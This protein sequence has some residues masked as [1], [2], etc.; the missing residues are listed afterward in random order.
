MN[1]EAYDP[2]DLYD[3][4]FAEAGVLRPEMRPV[5]QH[6]YQAARND[7]PQLKHSLEAVLK[8][9]GA[10]F[11][12]DHEERVLPFDPIPRIIAAAEW[13]HVAVGLQQ[14][15]TALNRFCADI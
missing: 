4:Y 8:D 7:L 10:T 13:Q 3:E 12:E 14:R 5:L 15:V 11:S 2:Q 9:L 1:F 6:L